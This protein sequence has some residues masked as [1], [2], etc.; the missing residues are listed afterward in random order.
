MF[1]LSD[2][3]FLDGRY[4]GTLTKSQVYGKEYR[5]RDST[6]KPYVCDIDACGKSFYHR[7]NMIR[8]QRTAHPGLVPPAGGAPG[9]LGRGHQGG[10]EPHGGSVGGSLHGVVPSGEVQSRSP[11]SEE[12]SHQR[13][14]DHHGYDPATGQNSAVFDPNMAAFSR[15]MSAPLNG[16]GN[17]RNLENADSAE[18]DLK[19]E[20]IFEGGERTLEGDRSQDNEENEG[21]GENIA[22]EF[23]AI[24]KVEE[25]S[26]NGSSN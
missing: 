19:R 20:N 9:N 6:N 8:H 12:G 7:H 5:P 14:R 15:Q 26:N 16:G 3:S 10:L 17:E 1:P 21:A 22:D 25:D 24:A 18:R 13:N 2:A 4:C 11:E 23:L